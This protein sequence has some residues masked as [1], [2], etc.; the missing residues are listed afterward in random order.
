M[1]AGEI[2]TLLECPSRH[3]GEEKER[4]IVERDRERLWRET[5]KK[6]EN[7]RERWT[8][9]EQTASTKESE[10]ERKKP[11]REREG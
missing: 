9:E 5:N 4:E 2:L 3:T 11:G 7:M 6:G 10:R 1:T 8:E